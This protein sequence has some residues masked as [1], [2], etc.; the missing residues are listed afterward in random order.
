MRFQTIPKWIVFTLLL[1]TLSTSCWAGETPKSLNGVKVVTASE[2][3][4]M[5]ESGVLVVDTRVA[6]EYAEKSIKGAKNI[7]YKELSGKDVAFDAGKDNFD[8]SK[9]P[10]DKS[11]QIVFFCN[12]GDCWKS[13]KASV[14]ALKAGYTKIHWFRG[15]FPEWVSA[16][17]PVQ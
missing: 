12:A 6:V 9:L 1:L 16:G 17:F 8:L 15:G 3:K 14:V 10:S 11:A 7:P 2:V 4:K 5:L 13:Y